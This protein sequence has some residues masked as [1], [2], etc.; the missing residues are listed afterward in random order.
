MLSGIC[1]Y[2]SRAKNAPNKARLRTILLA[3]IA[4]DSAQ[5]LSLLLVP[6]PSDGL[7]IFEKV[8][9]ALFLAQ[10]IS[11]VLLGELLKLLDE[12]L[13]AIAALG[14]KTQALNEI[15]KQSISALS[16]AMMHR[17]PTTAGHEKRVADLAVAVGKEPGFEPDRLEVLYLAALVH[18]V[19][20]IQIPAE[21]LT[22][23]RQLS[24]EEFELIK[25]H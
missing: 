10:F 25:S 14:R 4:V 21:I 13:Q 20:Q 8:G 9:L 22:R 23:P 24:P 15:L 17:D 16:S 19:G 3:G 7:P 18:D 11:T 1:I 6:L 12:R 5:T 2:L